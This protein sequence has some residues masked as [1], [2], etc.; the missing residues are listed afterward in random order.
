MLMTPH[1]L[2]FLSS[3]ST[4]NGHGPL[5]TAERWKSLSIM[6]KKASQLNLA[7]MVTD[8]QSLYIWNVAIE[9]EP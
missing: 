3:F 8:E 9:A 1:S 6:V 4:L 7:L 5:N 2:T